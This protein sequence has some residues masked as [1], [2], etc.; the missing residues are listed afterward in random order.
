MLRKQRFLDAVAVRRTSRKQAGAAHFL[1][2]ERCLQIRQSYSAAFSIF[3]LA[4][5]TLG[6][7]NLTDFAVIFDSCSVTLVAENN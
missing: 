3:A 5:A 2:A 1:S 4:L 6:L 7:S